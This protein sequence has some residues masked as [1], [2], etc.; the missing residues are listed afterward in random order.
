MEFCAVNNFVHVV[1]RVV[2]RFIPTNYKV[3]GETCSSLSLESLLTFLWC[4]FGH[5]D[6]LVFICTKLLVFG[7]QLGLGEYNWITRF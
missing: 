7:V 3:S 5:N 6:A 4:L 2:T 1:W